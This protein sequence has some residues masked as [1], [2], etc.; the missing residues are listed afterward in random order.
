MSR[1]QF[2]HCFV[3]TISAAD[4]FEVGYI[5][6]QLNDYYHYLIWMLEA[7]DRIQKE[8][9]PDLQVKADLMENL[10]YA[11]HHQGNFRQA[12]KIA[13]ELVEFRTE[14]KYLK[15]LVHYLRQIVDQGVASNLTLPEV[16]NYRSGWFDP[17]YEAL[18]RG[19]IA[20]V[21]ID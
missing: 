11:L 3:L 20:M 9:N 16:V 8:T 19:D 1:A 4:C 14:S 18:C 2:W 5:A 15:N 6:Y 21:F 7:Y 13:Q 12:V 10:A 17:H